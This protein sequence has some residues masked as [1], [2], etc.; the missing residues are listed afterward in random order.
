VDHSAPGPVA[1]TRSEGG[2]KAAPPP[3]PAAP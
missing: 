1:S 3:A 2:A